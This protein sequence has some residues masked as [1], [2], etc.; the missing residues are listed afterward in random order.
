MTYTEASARAV[1]GFRSLMGWDVFKVADYCEI[2]IAEARS[3]FSFGVRI[4]EEEHRKQ[5]VRG[6]CGREIIE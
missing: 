6:L 5:L 1:W 4:M 3:L 2:T